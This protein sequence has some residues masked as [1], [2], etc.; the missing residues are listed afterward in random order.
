MRSRK[1]SQVTEAQS[2]FEDVMDVDIIGGPSNQ[3]ERSVSPPP[4]REKSSR[5][6]G[7]KKV[8]YS[9]GEG[10]DE[11]IDAGRIVN[12]EEDEEFVEEDSPRRKSGNLKKSGAG[13]RNRGKGLKEK[14]RRGT[15][16]DIVMKDE[17]RA[18]GKSSEGAATIAGTKRRRE[19]ISEPPVEEGA[20][21]E[22]SIS[23]TSS[24]I[25]LSQPKEETL[26]PATIQPHL[27]MRKLPPIK[28]NK[29]AISYTSGPSTPVSSRGDSAAG[30]SSTNPGLPIH[31]SLPR[32]PIAPL[33]KTNDI[34]LS[35]PDIYNSLFK[36]VASAPR[37]GVNSRLKEEER[38][39]ELMRMRDETR[40]ARMAELQRNCFD[41]AAGQ[42]KVARFEA[43]LRNRNSPALYPNH[44]GSAI[45]YYVGRGYTQPFQ[46]SP[47]KRL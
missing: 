26:P 18:S 38:R 32:K 43:S 46:G 24:S 27:K 17:R 34:D 20:N 11:F 31:V 41:L 28:K 42:E 13:M 33:K 40:A 45:K 47:P 5:K 12:E 36:G 6:R 15:V 35:S 23:R 25:S 7:K 37:V 44:L 14:E 1:H 22:N 10:D 9:D 19:T 39:R 16:N 8:V 2:L 30:E 29:T 4:L 21:P 3:S